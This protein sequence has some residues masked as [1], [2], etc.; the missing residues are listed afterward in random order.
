MTPDF[1]I[2]TALFSACIGVGFVIGWQTR[3]KW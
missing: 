3:S 1:A 2:Y